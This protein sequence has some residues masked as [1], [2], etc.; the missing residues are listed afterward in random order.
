MKSHGHIPGKEDGDWISSSFS[1]VNDEEYVPLWLQSMLAAEVNMCQDL[2]TWE[3]DIAWQI[4]ILVAP[5]ISTSEEV[6]IFAG[7]LGNR[8][9]LP[10]KSA[11]EQAVHQYADG[12]KAAFLQEQARRYRLKP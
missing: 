9:L 6:N 12:F 8:E 2:F 10:L 11:M 3:S 5:Y 7:L 1:E 4:G